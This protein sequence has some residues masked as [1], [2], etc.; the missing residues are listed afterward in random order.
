[1]PAKWPLFINNVSAKLIARSAKSMGLPPNAPGIG[2]FASFLADEYVAAVSTA[3]TPFG[4]TH[5]NAGVKA[6]LAEGFDKAFKKLFEDYETSLEDRKILSQYQ[7]ITEILPESDLTFDAQCEI[8]K[9]TSE[10]TDTLQKFNYYPLYKSTCPVPYP[11]E[12]PNDTTNDGDIDFSVVTKASSDINAPSHNYVVRFIIKKFNPEQSFKIRYTINEIEQPLLS[13]GSVGSGAISQGTGSGS[14]RGAG[15]NTGFTVINVPAVPGKYTY[16]FKEILDISGKSLIKTINKTKSITIS[17]GGVL[18]KLSGIDEKLQGDAAGYPENITKPIR[19]TIPDLTEEEKIDVLVNRILIGNDNSKAYKKWVDLLKYGTEMPRK[20]R[21][22]SEKIYNKI[23]KLEKAWRRVEWEKR[24]KLVKSGANSYSLTS[25]LILPP[26]Y[27]KDNQINQYVFQEEHKQRPEEITE[28]IQKDL[29]KA[30]TYVPSI[31][32]NL[33]RYTNTSGVFWRRNKKESLY[34]KEQERWWET[35]RKWANYMKEINSQDQGEDGE[36]PYEIMAGAII[37]YWQ[38]AA[39]QPFTSGP[40]IPPCN[41]TAPLLGVFTPIYYGS[42]TSLANDLRRAWNNG[43]IF[44]VPPATPVAAT[45]VATAVAGACA[46][47]LLKLKFLYLGG[48]STPGGPIP[49]VG[50]M[51]LSF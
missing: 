6:V 2:D 27:V 38:S 22:L 26:L 45:L 28:E 24:K 31:D 17:D 30:F 23:K 41:I 16:T 34:K 37:K 32:G 43:K 18:E 9:W 42:K 10:N 7:S 5:S 4:N 29:I 44:E 40:P 15:N 35:Q 14:G 36:D 19:N 3:Q 39:A 11:E 8:E 46:K 33:A 13:I 49:M 47:H 25:S 51:P 20:H 48:I 50:F 21:A 12:D 1:M